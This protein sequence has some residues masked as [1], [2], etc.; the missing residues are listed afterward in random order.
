MKIIHHSGS[1]LLGAEDVFDGILA[2][3]CDMG[4]VSN[5]SY[6]GRF[7]LSDISDLPF[8]YPNMEIAGAANHEWL[9][10]YAMDTELKDVKLMITVPMAG[11]QYLGNT[12]I[13][14]LEDFQ[15]LNIRGAGKSDT[16][17]YEQLGA[18]GVSIPTGDAF[19][20]LD[21][22]MVDGIFFSW[23]GSLAFGFND[24]TTYR[25]DCALWRP[26]HQLHLSRQVYEDLPDD[27]KKIF[28]ELSTPE[29]SRKYAAAHMAEA[30]VSRASLAR[31][32]ERKGNPPIYI[33]PA[34][35]LQRW[36]EA[37]DPLVDSWIAEREKEGFP[38]QEMFDDLM[39]IVESY[40]Q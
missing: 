38:G 3:V 12:E 23:S 5:A 22:G 1:S 37:L 34:D 4:H 27:I 18:I 36:K 8:I 26:V 40:S 35:E 2:G 25:T 31:G 33:P 20:A 17:I 15:G 21:T 32:D 24:V 16:A 9:L 39:N 6:P 29:I 28:D 13:K 10:K 30:E 7:P 11:Q 14:V 19:S